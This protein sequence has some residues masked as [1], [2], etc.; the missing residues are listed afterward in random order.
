MISPRTVHSQAESDHAR[1]Q[2][3]S[4]DSKAELAPIKLV[5]TPRAVRDE[6][7]ASLQVANVQSL[8][9]PSLISLHNSRP[10]SCRSAIKAQTP[11]VASTGRSPRLNATPRS[12]NSHLL[13]IHTQLAG[14][15]AYNADMVVKLPT[16]RAPHA[17]LLVRS[18]T[19]PRGMD[20]DKAMLQLGVNEELLRLEKGM[21]KLGICDQDIQASLEIR[22]HCGVSFTPA[23]TKSEA[24]L[25]FTEEQLRRIKAVKQLGTTEAEIL[26]IY[27]QRISELGISHDMA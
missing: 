15:Q 2:F 7:A 17:K 24:L 14:S 4:C 19:M 8:P 13:P 22:R 10:Q 6:V 11:C 23:Q 3:P 25:G 20:M 18:S 21:K 12:I 1:T 16:A 5:R 9:E 27:C 26:D